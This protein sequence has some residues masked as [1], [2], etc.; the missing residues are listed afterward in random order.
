[1]AGLYPTPLPRTGWVAGLVVALCVGVSTTIALVTT[2]ATRAHDRP[3]AGG[4]RVAKVAAAIVL[5]LAV[6]GNLWWQNGIRSELGYPP[7]GVD[8]LATLVVPALLVFGLLAWAPRIT[9]VA[10]AM[11][12]ALG[13]GY[14]PA[15]AGATAAQSPRA[16][17]SVLYAAMGGAPGDP[18]AGDRLLAARADELVRRWVE[19]DGLDQRAVVL[20]VPTGSGWVDPSAVSAIDERFDGRVRV[21]ALQYADISSWRAFVGDREAAGRSVIAVLRRV[22]DAVQRDRTRDDRCAARTGPDAAR[23][24][25]AAA[26]SIYLYGQSLGALGAD[27]ARAWADARYPGAIAG[28]LLAGLPADSI[29]RS[30]TGT[31][32]IV[33]ANDSDPVARWSTALVWRPAQRPVETRTIGR[34]ARSVPWLPVISFVQSTAD[35]IGSLGGPTGVGHRYGREQGL[36]PNRVPA[37]GQLPAIGP[38]AAS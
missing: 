29:P 14:V 11:I 27:R 19:A 20:A 2:R 30:A 23:A 21:L 17:S 5:P 26:V 25:T 37:T 22:I 6:L 8:W 3:R 9:G 15:S 18:K 28:T 12:V 36:L 10:A 33:V 38:R 4:G 13:A 31:P 1:M 16:P 35:L 24:G 7:A 32:R 34:P